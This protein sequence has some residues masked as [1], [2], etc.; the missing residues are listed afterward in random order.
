MSQTQEKVMR[1]IIGWST[2]SLVASLVLLATVVAADNKD[3]KISLDKAPKAVQDAIKARFPDGEVTSVE[4]E[5][6][7]GKVVYDIELKLKGRKYEMDILEDGTVIEIE[8][9]IAAKDL[10][11]AVSKALEAKYPRATIKEVMEVYKV[12][13]KDEKLTEYEVSLETADKELKEV[14]VSLDG[15]SIK[16][17]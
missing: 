6:E 3:K 4:K 7:D 15:K 13:D 17:E 11:A 5:T 16:E 1:K 14:K 12:K 8:K 10:P 2:T 9:E